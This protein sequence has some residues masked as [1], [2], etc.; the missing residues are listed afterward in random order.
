MHILLRKYEGGERRFGW[1]IYEAHTLTILHA[2]TYQSPLA[3]VRKLHIPLLGSCDPST[4][5][6][7]KRMNFREKVG[8]NVSLKGGCGGECFRRGQE[9]PSSKVL[10]H[11]KLRLIVALQVGYFRNTHMKGIASRPAVF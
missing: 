6:L 5:H 10:S 1:E 2:F 9:L 7:V 8:K 4:F 11:L 3:D